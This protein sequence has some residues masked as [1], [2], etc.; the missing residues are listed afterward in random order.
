M[1]LIVSSVFY[2]LP[3]VSG[4]SASGVQLVCAD[5]FVL[6]RFHQDTSSFYSRGALLFFAILLNAFG[7]ALEVGHTARS[8]IE[9][10]LLLTS[11]G[12][13]SDL[14]A[15]CPTTHRRKARTIC[16]LSSVSRGRRFDAHRHAV[17]NRQRH[18]LQ[19]DHRGSRRLALSFACSAC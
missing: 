12:A 16:L 14:D 8:P 7:S 13:L 18:L 6:L 2:N 17:Q 3:M 15:L 1:G 5:G 10:D 11:T 19:P 9:T 4:G